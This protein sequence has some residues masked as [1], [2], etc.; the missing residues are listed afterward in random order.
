MKTCATAWN[1]LFDS[2]DGMILC[3]IASV[4]TGANG[5]GSTGNFFVRGG[6]GTGNPGP[7]YEERSILLISK[8]VS[9]LCSFCII[10]HLPV[11]FRYVL[12]S[13]YSKNMHT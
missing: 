7:S 1:N 9:F 5:I 3:A 13:V 8:K 11:R 6:A 2:V 12:F 10:L 4:T